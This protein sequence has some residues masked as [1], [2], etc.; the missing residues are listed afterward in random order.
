MSKLSRERK[1]RKSQLISTFGVGS[2]MEFPS[3]TLI[4]AGTDAWTTAPELELVD[5]RLARR[6]GVKNFYEPIQAK[7]NHIEGGGTIPFIRFP[8]WQVCPRCRTM[9][10]VHWNDRT[11]RTC[12]SEIKPRSGGKPCSSLSKSVKPKLTAVRF[13]VVCS[14]GHIDDFPW[15][16]WAHTQKREKLDRNSGCSNPILRLNPTGRAGLMGLTVHCISCDSKRS[17]MGSASPEILR[18]YGCSGKRPWL[19]PDGQQKCDSKSPPRMLQ[20]GATNVYFSNV[21]SSILIPPHSTYIRRLI[22][23]KDN[24]DFLSN[25]IVDGQTDTVRLKMFAEMNK[26]PLDELTEAVEERLG[27]FDETRQD[28][29]EA[30]YRYDEFQAFLSGKNRNENDD[31]NVYPQ[32]ITDYK[33]NT[34]DFF[35][36]IVLVE[37]LTE[38]RALTG[39][40]R[41]EPPVHGNSE[42][43]NL[44]PLSKKKLSWLPAV[45][46]FGEGIFITLNQDLI[47]SWNKQ[48]SVI[49]NFNKIQNRL[50]EVQLQR[51]RE[52]RQISPAFILL[53][54]LAH[55]LIR[56]LSFECG[57]GSSSLRERLYCI[58]EGPQKMTGLLIYT[59]ASDAEGTLG[60][61]VLQGKCGHLEHILE[62][63]L[64]DAA[65][66]SSDPLCTENN[67]QGS[68]ALN[69]AACHACSLIP[70]TSCEE[71]NR[72][73]DR[74]MVIG[75][76]NDESLGF[77]GSF[78]N[79]LIS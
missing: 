41:L 42:Q 2:L 28:Q 13:I 72:L 22:S 68:D 29:S 58:Q 66:C 9:H 24:W 71:G 11:P 60:G 76:P 5:D 44:A 8:L 61:L 65:N 37:K 20:R 10:K 27:S 47:E 54:T 1:I 53:H 4:H 3:E 30:E 12:S 16:E 67:G 33:K 18:D 23:R 79:K 49:N 64:I 78:L 7:E 17:M 51:S 32:K 6:L 75:K 55:L 40:S 39:F 38:T 69:L 26:L 56:R 43:S 31:L 52:F 48:A 36:N 46:A 34:R 25:G 45:R 14:S 19:G 21:V 57:Y 70:E 73:L 59:S 63:A 62:H 77:F 15:I 74:C 50:K 35:S